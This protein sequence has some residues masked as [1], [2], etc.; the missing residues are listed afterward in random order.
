MS[1]YTSWPR[2]PLEWDETGNLALMTT[3]TG[4]LTLVH[5]AEGRLVAVNDLA[6]GS[7]IISYDYDALGRV[8][9]HKIHRGG[10]L[11]SID[12]SFVYDGSVCIQ[13]LS[14]DGSGVLSPD[15]TF[16]CADGIGQ[17]IST[18]NGTIY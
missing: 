7:P 5:D 14:D 16:V 2:G 9:I 17:C 6:T 13:E 8:M 15:M 4:S 12:S 1:Q 11:P 10:G 3:A 18:R